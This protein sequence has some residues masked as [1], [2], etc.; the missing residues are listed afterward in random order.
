MS[1]KKLKLVCVDTFIMLI[2]CCALISCTETTAKKTYKD[3]N[4]VAS[5]QVNW[6]GHWRDEGK[7][8]K[9]VRE[10]A[11]EFEFLNQD[12]K[13]NLIFP[14]DLY[15]QTNDD[16]VSFVIKMIKS[17]KPEYDI[18]R[19]KNN[20]IPISR[21]LNDPDWGKKYL[22]D[23][24]EIP[25]FVDN[26]IPL[27]FTETFKA[28]NGGITVGPY[29]EGYFYSVWYNKDLADKIGIKIKDLEMTPDDFVG[30]I[31]AVYDYNKKNST[32]I[33][34]LYETGSWITTEYLMVGMFYSMFDNFSEIT[35]LA[36]SQK[37]LENLEK[38]LKV[39]ETM[40]QYNPLPGNRPEIVFEKT[41]DYPLKGKCLLYINASWMYNDWE[42]IDKENLMKMYPAE[43][44][45]FKKKSP[46]YVGGYQACWAVLKNA[47]NRE[48]AVKLMKYWTT[49]E[50]AEKWVRYTKSPTAIKGNLTSV[51][52][53]LNQF[54]NFEYVMTSKYGP[55]LL[56]AYDNR[57]ILGLKNKD[58][59]IPVT[60]I[61]EKKL[62]VD[63][64]IKDIKRQIKN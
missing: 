16:D 52:L 8:A 22:V 53:G 64:F 27:V 18:I 12:I 28:Q 37:K 14:E 47:P 61:L 54:E 9:L 34:P 36:F 43:M 26:H 59:K 4:V 10:M 50:L 15:K 39:F 13:V 46:C 40:A 38:V 51:T 24:S 35:D 55:N 25:D 2:A 56:T 42:N 44:P 1:Q 32:D 49:K 48:N 33:I 21:I 57:Y 30:Y 58:I 45:S 17:P 63:Q 5:G 20:Y 62:T 60:D 7:K 3:S 19:I 23:F 11:N 31:K 29:N 6:I 41:M